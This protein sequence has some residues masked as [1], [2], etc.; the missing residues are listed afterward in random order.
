M[1]SEQNCRKCEYLPD[2]PSEVCDSC[3][4]NQGEFKLF[5]QKTF[6]D[7]EYVGIPQGSKAFIDKHFE[8][9]QFRLID[10]RP[11]TK[12]KRKIEFTGSLREHQTPAVKAMLK[13]YR[14]NDGGCG[15][16]IAQPRTGKTVMATDIVCQ[17]GMKTLIIAKQVDWLLQ[18]QETFIGSETQKP[19]TDIPETQQ[20]HQTK[21]IGLCKTIADFK[22]YDIC[23][24]TYQTFLSDNGQVKYKELRDEFPVIIIDETHSV[25]AAEFSKI[26]NGF[27]SYIRLGLTATFDRK[28]GMHWLVAAIA[29]P[30]RYTVEI[31][32]LKPTVE[33][34]LTGFSATLPKMWVYALKKLCADKERNKLILKHVMRDVED[35]RSIVIPVTFV[36]HARKL[37]K[38]INKRAGENIAVAFTGG[39]NRRDIILGAREGKYKVVVGTRSIVQTGI[40]IPKWDT[41]YEILPSSNIPSCRQRLSRILTPMPGKPVPCIKYFLD[42]CK[43]VRSCFTAEF[44]GA[45]MPYIKPIVSQYTRMLVKDYISGK[46]GKKKE[47]IGGEF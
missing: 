11:R 26:L 38:A 1:F 15:S 20:F 16:L 37:V 42:E 27:N 10:K 2:R 47:M 46:T 13:Y 24:A 36:D 30:P 35:G 18:F 5:V 22:K 14:D 19:L 23:L 33:I 45:V 25:G 32:T 29:G 43:L 9:D 40:N 21:I 44:Y 34:I 12:F 3:P 41:I 7:V 28:D 17:L 8:M 6:K 4:S 39:A 31:E